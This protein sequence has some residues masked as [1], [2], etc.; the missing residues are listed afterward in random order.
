MYVKIPRLKAKTFYHKHSDVP[1]YIS[2]QARNDQREAFLRLYFSFMFIR[3]LAS[4]QSNKIV[5]MCVFVSY[6]LTLQAKHRPSYYL[7]INIRL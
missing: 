7:Y 1:K 6:G 4:M 5:Y 2:K 3:G